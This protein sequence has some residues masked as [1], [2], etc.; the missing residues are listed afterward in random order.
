LER[1]LHGRRCRAALAALGLLAV[2]GTANLAAEAPD[3]SPGLAA[4]SLDAEIQALIA[5]LSSEEYRAREAA[6]EALIA[7]GPQVAPYIDEAV[8]SP[9]LEVHTRAERIRAIISR[10]FFEEEIQAF[11]ADA[12]GSLGADLPG[13]ERARERLRGEP[14]SREL[15][16]EMYRAEPALFEAYSQDA[17]AAAAAFTS[18]VEELHQQ[19]NQQSTI[20]YKARQQQQQAI[21][22]NV[23][24]LLFVGAD[25]SLD[26]PPVSA[27]NFKFLFIQSWSPQRVASA[28][29][30]ELLRD[31]LSA[32]IAVRFGKP[33]QEYEGIMLGMDYDIPQTLQLAIRVLRRD[34]KQAFALMQAALCV[35]QYGDAWHLPH[36]E[37][38]LTN[39]TRVQERHR[40][41]NQRMVLYEIQLRDIALLALVHRTGQDV[42]EYGFEEIDR[43]GGFKFLPQTMAFANQ[44]DRQQ[45][46]AKWL[47]WRER[48]RL[49]EGEPPGV[50]FTVELPET[51][52]I[53]PMP[54]E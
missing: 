43:H 48:H 10:R 26:L 29:E 9:N 12:D 11:L 4:A 40:P 16:A 38:L 47:A 18:R 46:I 21:A 28:P 25:E 52:G 24:A 36:L 20:N 13:W 45:A 50:P 44:D 7:L 2:I 14:G 41:V 30:R 32:W 27:N 22:M 23:A 3:G 15:F 6:T 42:L 19:H 31:W 53:P 33:H 39:V 54:E 5:Q 34:E 8:D 1:A 37:P 49:F 35:G 51:A 17:P